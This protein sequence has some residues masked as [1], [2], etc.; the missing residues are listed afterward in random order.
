MGIDEG[1]LLWSYGRCLQGLRQS[2]TQAAPLRMRRGQMVGI[3]STPVAK[4][5]TTRGFLTFGHELGTFQNQD[6]GSLAKVKTFPVQIERLDRQ[7]IVN[8]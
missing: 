1:N 8:H 2:A 6:P 7:G 4:H 5:I 3:G